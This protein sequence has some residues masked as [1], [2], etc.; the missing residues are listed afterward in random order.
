V[1]NCAEGFSNTAEVSRCSTT[2]RSPVGARSGG[3]QRQFFCEQGSPGVCSPRDPACGHGTREHTVLSLL[4]LVR[5]IAS[6][7]RRHLPAQVELGD[8]INEGVLGLMDAVRRF[9]A[10]RHVKIESYARH[11]IRGAIL[12]SLRRTDHASRDIRRKA[13]QAAHASADLEARLGRPATSS[14]MARALGMSLDEWYKTAGEIQAASGSGETSLDQVEEDHPPLSAILPANHKDD[15]YEMCYRREQKEIFGRAL[16]CLGERD[17]AIIHLYYQNSM[18]M[19]EIGERLDIDE[20]RV[21]QLHSR[22][23][24]RLEQCV[25]SLTARPCSPRSAPGRN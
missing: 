18:T 23:L 9:D 13:H 3:R 12:D 2:S 22:A 7:M 20:S 24:G 1:A 15:P 17:R 25:R 16:A 21:S 10:A 14:E 8:L 6:Q 11:R 4:P 19:K 5:Q